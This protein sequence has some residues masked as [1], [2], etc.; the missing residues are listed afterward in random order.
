MIGEDEYIVVGDLMEEGS[1]DE[2]ADVGCEM[3]AGIV[4]GVNLIPNKIVRTS[5]IVGIVGLS[6]HLSSA[7]VD[8]RYSLDCVN[9]RGSEVVVLEDRRWITAE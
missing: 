3:S 8:I 4:S 6:V 9:E 1:L 5:W 2:A 7:I